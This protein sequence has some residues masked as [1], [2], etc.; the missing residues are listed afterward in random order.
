[1]PEACDCPFCHPQTDDYKDDMKADQSDDDG[2]KLDDAKEGTGGL[3]AAAGGK[4][5]K[6]RRAE[7]LQRALE[8]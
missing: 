6:A 8:G 5:S 2:A 3:G 4:L 1:M 7:A